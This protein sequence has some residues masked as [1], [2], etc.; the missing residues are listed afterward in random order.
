MVNVTFLYA[1]IFAVFALA[2]SAQARVVGRCLIDI[3]IRSPFLLRTADPP[4]SAVVG[5]DVTDLQRIGKRI[6][7]GFDNGHWHVLHLMIAGRLHWKT[8]KPVKPTRAMLASYEFEHGVLT[9]TEAG[10][11]RRASLHVVDG[12]YVPVL[13]NELRKS[14]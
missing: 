14:S 2:L 9:L 8:G 5:H 4:V 10:S 12:A 3:Q 7:L 1:E 11:K 13:L 6:A